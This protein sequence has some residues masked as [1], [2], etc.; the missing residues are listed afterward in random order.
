MPA[1]NSNKNRALDQLL[2][3][4]DRV[5]RDLQQATNRSARNFADAKE[6]ALVGDSSNFAFSALVVQSTESG[7]RFASTRIQHGFQSGAWLRS[8]RLVTDVAPNSAEQKRELLTDVS[9]LQIQ[10]FDENS[11]PS[12]TWPTAASS[13]D[14]NYNLDTLPKAI[15]IKFRR[16][17]Y[18]EIR[19]L[20]LIS[21]DTPRQ[22]RRD[23]PG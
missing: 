9:N 10:Y 1:H 23:A 4:L 22:E 5:E 17:P 2:R 19:K 20:I 18:G 21:V 12:P 16:P 11:V 15:E 7:A 6:P 3:A 13:Y 8:E 14:P